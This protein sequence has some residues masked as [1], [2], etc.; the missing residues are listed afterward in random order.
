M[1]EKTQTIKEG[2]RVIARDPEGRL[3]PGEYTGYSRITGMYYVSFYNGYTGK[4]KSLK[5]ITIAN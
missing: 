3:S 1:K 2:Q 4:F 5:Y